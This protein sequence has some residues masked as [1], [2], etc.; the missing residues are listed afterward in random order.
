MN[1]AKELEAQR[2]RVQALKYL[3][4]QGQTVATDFEVLAQ[5]DKKDNKRDNTLEL[6]RKQKID[7]ETKKSELNAKSKLLQLQN[8]LVAIKKKEQDTKNETKDDNI[9]DLPGN[10]EAI[11]DDKSTKY[12][13]WNRVTNTTTWD[14]PQKAELNTPV[15]EGLW[16]QQFHQ[17][18]KQNYWLNKETGEKRF[19][20]A[21]PVDIPNSTSSS[22]SSTFGKDQM[23]KRPASSLSNGINV[24]KKKKIFNI[25]PLDITQGKVVIY[26]FHYLLLLLISLNNIG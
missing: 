16:V 26:S 7:E 15:V 19:E 14:K 21:M 5:I 6:L 10:W 25:D 24:I 22:S 13:Y 11:F 18:S 17:G 4:S 2:K 1:L 20:V 23:K 8:D 9:G 12:Y 3:E